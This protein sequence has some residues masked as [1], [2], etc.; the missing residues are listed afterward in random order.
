MKTTWRE[1]GSERSVL[2]PVSLI[3]SAFAPV[4]D[5]RATLTPELNLS[6]PSRLLLIDLGKG[7]NRSG[8][9]CW[10]QVHLKNGGSPPDLDSPAALERDV[11]RIARNEGSRIGARLS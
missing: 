7:K 6:Q 3:V 10:A 9:S 1:G 5:A 2:A 8:G 11:F 4:Q